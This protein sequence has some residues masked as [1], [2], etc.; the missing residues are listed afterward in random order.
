MKK[1][2]VATDGSKNSKRALLEAKSYAKCTGRDV[3]IV[4]VIEPLG[5]YT[6]VGYQ[7]EKL[8]KRARDRG[9]MLL[10][11]AS[12]L[13]A[14]LEENVETKLLVGNPGD[15]IIK[16]SEE[17]DYDL[18]IMGS[19]GLGTFQRAMLGSVSNKVLNHG[20]LNVFIV[21]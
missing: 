9:N 6:T 11:K 2:L 20:K 12:E 7:Y 15:K 19:R 10:E 13:L 1:I 17:D 4:T 3:I 5:R 18:I 16:E 14:D 21:K 8:S